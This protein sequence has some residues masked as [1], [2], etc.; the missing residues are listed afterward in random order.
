MEEI[1]DVLFSLIKENEKEYIEFK[2]AK[3]NFDFN[4]LGKY[5]SALSNE[6]L[7]LDNQVHI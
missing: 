5:F 3:N 1:K 6:R 7:E 4:E 2:E